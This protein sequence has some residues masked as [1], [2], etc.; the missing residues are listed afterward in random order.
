MLQNNKRK[1][2][3]AQFNDRDLV[4]S[5]RALCSNSLVKGKQRVK[6]WMDRETKKVGMKGRM[7]RRKEGRKTGRNEGRVKGRE[8]EREGKWK[9]GWSYTGLMEKAYESIGGGV[10][11]IFLCQVNKNGLENVQ[12]AI[13][14]M[15]WKLTWKQNRE[16]VFTD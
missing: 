2:F 10:I 4:L 12:E 11:S 1:R 9:E 5:E 8:E 7:D 16:N 6:R 3:G 15:D 13:W 14:K